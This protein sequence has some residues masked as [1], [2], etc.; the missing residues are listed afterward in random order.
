[1]CMYIHDH[2]SWPK[3]S[4]QMGVSC[5]A[6]NYLCRRNETFTALNNVCKEVQRTSTAQNYV[7]K[8]L[9][10][11]RRWWHPW[12]GIPK[13]VYIW[14][15]LLKY[16]SHLCHITTTY[17]SNVL[18]LTSTSFILSSI[19]HP[20]TYHVHLSSRPKTPIT[21]LTTNLLFHVWRT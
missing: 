19:I 13:R 5:T 9:T 18:W 15:I 3:G 21:P 14:M 16:Q 10:T 1:M 17:S 8:Y 6:L 11:A 12:W 2:W 4:Y 7:C 20:S